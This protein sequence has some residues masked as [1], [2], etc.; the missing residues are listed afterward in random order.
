[1]GVTGLL[2]LLWSHIVPKN[3]AFNQAHSIHVS[4]YNWAHTVNMNAVSQLEQNIN[5]HS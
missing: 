2:Q 1:V 4:T 5:T 3:H